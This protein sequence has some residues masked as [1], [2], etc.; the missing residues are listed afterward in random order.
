[1]SRQFNSQ[2]RTLGSNYKLTPAT[3][4]HQLNPHWYPSPHLMYISMQ[5]ATAIAQ[6][7]G[8][9]IISLPPRHGKSELITKYS[10]LWSLEHFPFWKVILA[11]YGA[12]LSEDFSREVREIV[13]NN[14][15]DLSIRIPKDSSKVSNW[16]TSEGGG[17]KAV[18]IGGPI[19]GSGADVLLID[20]YIKDIKEAM[21]KSYKDHIWNWFRTVAF[22]RLEPGGTC[23]VIAT[24]WAKDDLIGRLIDSNIGG[25]WT[26][27]VLPAI[28]LD[29]DLLGR[30]KGAPLFP[31]RYNKEALMAIKETMGSYFFN[32]LYQQD[33]QDDENCLTNSEWLQVVDIL[34]P[35]HNVPKARIWDLAATEHGGDYS[36]GT[37]MLH[38]RTDNLTYITNV[39]RRRLSSQGVESLV[40]QTAISD[41]TDTPIYIEQEPGSSGK[42]LV[43]HYQNVVLPEFK[44][45]AVPCSDGK[46]TRAQPFLA[47]AE[48]GKVRLLRGE[49]NEEFKREFQDFPGGEHDDQIDTAAIGYVK[50]SG[51]KTF[52]ASWGRNST[53][54]D[55]SNKVILPSTGGRPSIVFGRNRKVKY[56]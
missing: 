31:E 27:I 42:A 43:E 36:C 47:A 3:L 48:A 39:I 30:E 4:A 33:P 7:N 13:Y 35:L 26:N 52:S 17:L 21:S 44:V 56:A 37:H 22:T 40:R 6:G 9:I 14:Q 28:A 8:R 34:P 15:N 45:E 32:A 54:R 53:S 25:V 41:G 46:I 5:I 24:R 2:I 23:I 49:W 1:M 11:T 50:L 19:T 16:K 38:S 20:D 12:D 51:K 18:G 29:D 55:Q 10:T